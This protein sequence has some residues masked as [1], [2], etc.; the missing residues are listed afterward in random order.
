MPPL[1]RRL[2][3]PL[4][5]LASALLAAAVGASYFYVDLS[6]NRMGVSATAIGLN[7]SMPALGWLLATP[8]MPWALRRF[9]PKALLLGLLLVAV[10]AAVGFGAFPDANMWMGLR[11]L[12]GG[13][14]GMAFRLV[15]YW[16]NAASPESHRA[17]NV[18]IYATSFSAGAMVGGLATAQLGVEGW[19]PIVM[20]VVLVLAAAM[21]FAILP[22]GPPAIGASS[23][24][25]DWRLCLGGGF[26]AFVAILIYGMF[27]AV[28]F[29]LM[30]VYSVRQGL[31]DEWAVWCASA[32]LGGQIVL[33]TPL[34]M[35]G[36][37]VGKF[38]MLLWSTGVALA[39]PAVIPQTIATPEWLLLAMFVW[40][41]AA[42]S[43]YNFALA[44]LADCFE[45]AQL[46]SANAVFGTLYA[47]GSLCGPVLHGVAMDAWNPQGLMVSAACLFGLFLCVCVW[48]SWRLRRCTWTAETTPSL[49]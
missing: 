35:L 30:P 44:M 41:G 25:G 47:F 11:F 46:A 2:N 23:A 39:V 24:K 45:G 20:M 10:L 31:S 7:A 36:D 48:H 42:G 38:R 19:P 16:I 34:G 37:R 4:I 6:L 12:F 22:H 8:L 13:G 40:G 32:A 1:S 29:T 28:P 43:L 9:N 21:V 26:I 5:S 17:R 27:E 49:D 3:L 15:E 33:A 18:G 14:T